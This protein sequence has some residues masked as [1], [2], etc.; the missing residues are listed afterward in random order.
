MNRISWA[1]LVVAAQVALLAF[2]AGER[3]WIIRTGEPLLLRTAP[4]DPLDP[5][6]GAYARLDY[7]ISHAPRAQCRGA[8]VDWLDEVAAGTGPNRTNTVVFA[9]LRVDEAG[10]AELVS[11]SDE[12]PPDGPFLRG[13]IADL[14]PDGAEVRYGVEALFLQQDKALA[15]EREAREERRGVPV[16]TEVA[17]GGRG[18][19]V[20][21]GYRWENLGLTVEPELRE[22]PAEASTTRAPRRML[23]A[24]VAQLKNHGDT[25]LAVVDRPDGGSFR[26]V[27][28][29]RGA[30][31]GGYRWAGEATAVPPAQPADVRVLQP[32]ETWRVRLDLLDPRWHVIPP[33]KAAAAPAA[34]LPLGAV[35]EPWRASFRLEYVPPGA[36]ERASLPQGELIT[37]ARLRSATFNGVAFID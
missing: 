8:V 30:F 29:Q 22:E 14:S 16:N 7:D 28:N 10:V 6:R 19:A 13:R 4:I 18:V 34:F 21:T 3:E 24:V 23:V 20:I 35:T 5:M 36:T 15:F 17:V 2:M 31:D 27:S 25:P 32:G 11:L 26:L 1:M 9:A 37:P 12:P 33:T